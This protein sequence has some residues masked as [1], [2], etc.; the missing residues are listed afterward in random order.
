VVDLQI[1]RCHRTDSAS[2]PAAEFPGAAVDKVRGRDIFALAWGILT[3][4]ARY[5]VLEKLF[6]Q[7]SWKQTDQPM[8]GQQQRFWTL[9]LIFLSR[10]PRDGT[11][12][13]DP[14]TRRSSIR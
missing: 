3:S 1:F 14:R 11:A 6:S 5:N 2:H 10:L 13:I 9:L 4:R 8:N 7:R 12:R